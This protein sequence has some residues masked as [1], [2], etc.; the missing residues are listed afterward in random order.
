MVT[1]ISAIYSIRNIITNM[2]YIGASTNTQ[3]RWDKHKRYLKQNKHWNF[4]F[5]EEYNIYGEE[6]YEYTIIQLLPSD[7][8]LLKFMETYWIVYYD[9]FVDCGKGYN[10][11]YGAPNF[12]PSNTTRERNREAQKGKTMSEETKKKISNF[13][14]S[15]NNPHIG[16]KRSEESRKKMS[17]AGKVKIFTEEHKKHLSESLS[18]ENHPWF[19]KHLPE[20]TK[21]KIAEAQRGEKSP[22]FNWQYTEEEL[23]LISR[24]R[25]GIK[26][27]GEHTSI[28]VGVSFSEAT[29]EWRSSITFRKQVY[30]LG[31]FSNEINAA[32]AYDKKAI[33]LYGDNAKTNFSKE[34]YQ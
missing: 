9:S 30:N 12:C 18:G 23:D 31:F 25:Q 14:S 16:A 33:E 1:K 24:G 34:E 32:K 4:L 17:D 6:A 19:N 8:E 13:M 5:Q 27:S 3:K 11:T 26:N 29:C 21:E 7:K 10:L 22:R 2:R 28:Y 15:E 20:E